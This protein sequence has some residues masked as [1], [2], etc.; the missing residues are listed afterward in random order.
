MACYFV[1]FELRLVF[2]VG[3]IL[4]QTDKS[5]SLPCAQWSVAPVI[6]GAYA[7]KIV[8]LLES[9]LLIWIELNGFKTFLIPPWTTQAV[10]TRSTTRK[11]HNANSVTFLQC[12]IVQLVCYRVFNTCNNFMDH[13]IA[14][15]LLW[16]SIQKTCVSQWRFVVVWCRF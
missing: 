2:C 14:F 1:D 6:S 15:I 16:S 7:I 8:F 11:V 3:L 10:S 9:S 13:I 5:K 4:F 12:I